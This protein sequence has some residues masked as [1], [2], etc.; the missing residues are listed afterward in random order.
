M[1]SQKNLFTRWT[2]YALKLGFLLSLRAGIGLLVTVLKLKSLAAEDNTRQAALLIL[3]L[4]VGFSV[5]VWLP[6]L[7]NWGSVES[8]W[9]KDLSM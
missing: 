8:A 2:H 3:L 4:A 9:Q 5:I 7:L 1:R 6:Q